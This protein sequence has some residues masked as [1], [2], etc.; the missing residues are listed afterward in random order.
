M[1]CTQRTNY[2]LS[3][4]WSLNETVL[5]HRV[6]LYNPSQNVLGH[7]RKLGTKTHFAKLTCNL[8]LKK[9]WG[10]CYKGL[11]LLPPPPPPFL[12]SPKLCWLCWIKT[13]MHNVNTT[14]GGTGEGR[15]INL[16]SYCISVPRVLTRVV[17][18]ELFLCSTGITP[19]TCNNS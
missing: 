12:L 11:F 4:L 10:C 3:G 5:L 16:T 7:L 17:G 6:E 19:L 14:P 9:A 2:L 15:C 13:W 1:T 8:P 18:S